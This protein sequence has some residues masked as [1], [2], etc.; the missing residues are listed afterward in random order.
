MPSPTFNLVFRYEGG[1]G[2]VVWHLD[3]YRLTSEDQVFELGWADLGADDEIVLVEWPERAAG[4]LPADRWDIQ[5]D[6]HPSDPGL[7]H[8][9]AD[10]RGSAP[11]I[12]KPDS[13]RG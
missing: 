11:P 8:V 1:N 7:R 9:R 10:A 3:L 5:L 4:F 13:S 2:V 6:A 12:P